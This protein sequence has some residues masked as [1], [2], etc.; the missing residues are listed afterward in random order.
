MD[1]VYSART[2][3][4]VR[5]LKKDTDPFGLK[6]EGEEVLRQEYPYLSAIGA[7]MYLTNNMRPDIAF[8]VNYLTRHSATPTMCHWN[9]IKNILRYLV[10][11]IDLGLYF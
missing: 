2:P 5:A 6:E 4:V 3:M 8:I 1:K 7:L 9:D 11:T 10:G